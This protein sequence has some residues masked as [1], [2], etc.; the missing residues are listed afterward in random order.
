[1]QN[2]R[3]EAEE[4]AVGVREAGELATFRRSCRAFLRE[5][6]TEVRPSLWV[7]PRG[8]VD[9]AEAREF[10]AKLHRAGLAG[11]TYPVEFGGRG[12][13]NA[14]EQVWREEAAR[15]PLQTGRL[16]ISH[17]MC[18]P[19]LAEFGTQEQ[20]SH[21]LAKLLSADEVWCQLFSEPS[22]G[23]DVASLQTRAEQDGDAWVVNGQ[24]SWTTLA[25]LCERGILL[26]RTDPSRPKHKGISMFIVD[27]RAPGVE[28]RPINQIDGGVRFNEVFFTD[29]R[30]PAENLIPPQDEGWR[31]ATAMLQYE[32]LAIGTGQQGGV[33]APRADALIALARRHGVADDPMLRQDLARLYSAEICQSL[34]ALQAR[35]R[36]EAGRAPGPGGSLGKL[37]NV[38]VAAQVR[39]LALRISG[40][41]G[42]AW[43]RDDAEGDR[44]SRETLS[45]L[46]TGIAGGTN[47]VQRNIIGERVLG[48]PREPS[49]DRDRPFAASRGGRPT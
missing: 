39:S 9:L 42:V 21:Y 23:S 16:A 1:M 15:F 45:T 10:Q 32:R 38:G 20:K 27:M 2:C 49:V 44:W 41:A 37:A 35:A 18:L 30:I 25:H 33:H 48:L 28:I 43:L 3:S 26:A 19:V 8:D 46:G 31:L 5:H 6:A 34:L 47:E 14:H 36:Q 24:K 17:G 22:A 40:A 7:D 4:D 29:V 12:L 11:L 13:T